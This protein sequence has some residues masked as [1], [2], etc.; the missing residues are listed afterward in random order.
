[1]FPVMVR[2]DENGV[3]LLGMGSKLLT[4]QEQDTLVDGGMWRLH[5]GPVIGEASCSKSRSVSVCDVT[6]ASVSGANRCLVVR[7]DTWPTRTPF[8]CMYMEQ[9]L[10]R[11]QRDSSTESFKKCQRLE[12]QGACI[13]WMIGDKL[14]EYFF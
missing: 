4:E 1:M 3:D 5:K 11:T 13:S 10:G 6:F 8:H 14:L 2:L 12:G 7:V 9:M